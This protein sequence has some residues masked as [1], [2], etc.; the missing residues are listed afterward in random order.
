[1]CVC[2]CALC[3]A[4]HVDLQAHGSHVVR[5]AINSHQCGITAHTPQYT[6]VVT[7]AEVGMTDTV[8][9]LWRYSSAQACM[10]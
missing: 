1:M 8:V 7:N 3:I 6:M 10:R 4:P 5:T 2:V 9:E